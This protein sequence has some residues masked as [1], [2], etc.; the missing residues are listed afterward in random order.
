[1]FAFVSRAHFFSFVCTHVFKR[2]AEHLRNWLMTLDYSLFRCL[3]NSGSMLG[4][5]RKS[6]NL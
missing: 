5:A 4:G 3:P 1:M 6:S 2:R